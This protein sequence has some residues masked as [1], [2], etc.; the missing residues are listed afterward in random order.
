MGCAAHTGY[1]GRGEQNIWLTEDYCFND[2]YFTIYSPCDMKLKK[3]GVFW[4]F[5]WHKNLVCLNCETCLALECNPKPSWPKGFEKSEIHQHNQIL[6]NCNFKKERLLH[7][8]WIFME[9]VIAISQ[10][11]VYGFQISQSL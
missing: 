2:L 11:W 4:E 10:D 1:T 6:R 9:N 8:C 3:I 7:F 5:S